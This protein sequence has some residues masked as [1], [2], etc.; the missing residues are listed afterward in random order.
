V[1]IRLRP[2]LD[3]H[4]AAVPVLLFPHRR[5]LLH[6]VNGI[7]AGLKRPWRWAEAMAITTL[8]SP[9]SSRPTR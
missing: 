5:D 7:A 8:T 6:P 2:A 3:P 9:I 1:L 4:L